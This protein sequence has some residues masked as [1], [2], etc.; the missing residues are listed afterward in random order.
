M[1]LASVIAG[2]YSA[3]WTPAGGS[4][5]DLGI[6]NSPGGYHVS[7]TPDWRVINNTDAYAANA[8][9]AIWR[10]FSD[11]GVAFVAKEWKTGTIQ[12]SNVGSA[13]VVSGAGGFKSG[14]PGRRASDISGT[15]IMTSTATTP[16][17]NNPATATFTLVIPR[18]GFKHEWLLDSIE[19]DLPFDFQ[20]IGLTD[21]G[22]TPMPQYF[23]V[24]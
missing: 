17:A 13:F 11:V 21:G 20:V 1:P 3:T 9:D 7:F 16:A 22:G 12:A 19:R 14:I 8:I 2:R 18:P 5:A 6:T 10:G 15:I 24:T 23:S 4:P